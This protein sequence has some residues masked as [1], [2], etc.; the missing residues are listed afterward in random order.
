MY[1][2]HRFM[3]LALR[4]IFSRGPVELEM[5][6]QVSQDRRF[7]T[8]PSTTGTRRLL[9]KYKVCCLTRYLHSTSS[10]YFP[11]PRYS[12]ISV[13]QNMIDSHLDF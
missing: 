12:K 4:D 2:R 5:I 9:A 10:W 1:A 8:D 6:A 7:Q 11:Q 13:N 3:S